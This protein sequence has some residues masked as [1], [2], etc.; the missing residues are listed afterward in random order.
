MNQEMD[1]TKEK[2]KLA[3]KSNTELETHIRKLGIMQ[4]KIDA[5]NSKDG[6]LNI[7]LNELEARRKMLGDKERN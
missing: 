1:V 3:E 4:K 5:Q 7:E 2:L 6:K